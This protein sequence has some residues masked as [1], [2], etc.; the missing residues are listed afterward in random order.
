[1]FRLSVWGGLISHSCAFVY[2]TS[3]FYDSAFDDSDI[4]NLIN[5]ETV[6][7]AVP[8]GESTEHDPEIP[9]WFST[10]HG[11]FIIDIG[12]HSGI[13]DESLV[14]FSLNSEHTTVMQLLKPDRVLEG[15]VS[16]LPGGAEG[17]RWVIDATW[18][19]GESAVVLD[20]PIEIDFRTDDIWIPVASLDSV[21][22]AEQ[23]KRVGNRIFFFCQEMDASPRV[24]MVIG[25][26][27]VAVLI[28]EVRV[29]DTDESTVNLRASGWCP[30]NI[31]ISDLNDY[32]TIG[33]TILETNDVV[34]DGPN[35][36]ILVSEKTG[37]EPA[38]PLVRYHLDNWSDTQTSVEW[39][40]S[41]GELKDTDFIFTKLDIDDGEIELICLGDV[42]EDVVPGELQDNWVGTPRIQVFGDSV[43]I[44]DTLGWEKHEV[45]V[46]QSG[47]EIELKFDACGYRMT[48]N[49]AN[50]IRGE[51]LVFVPVKGPRTSGEFGVPFWPP[52]RGSSMMIS[53]SRADEIKQSVIGDNRRWHGKPVLETTAADHV[54]IRADASENG[55]D[56]LVELISTENLDMRLDFSMII[57]RYRPDSGF[58]FVPLGRTERSDSEFEVMLKEGEV[59]RF[60]IAADGSINLP[61][62]PPVG[63][64]FRAHR[65]APGPA[66]WTG[67]PVLSIDPDSGIMRISPSLDGEVWT[68]SCGWQRVNTQYPRLVFSALP[69]RLQIDPS[70]LIDL[71]SSEWTLRSAADDWTGLTATIR[72]DAYLTRYPDGS[73]DLMLEYVEGPI[74]STGGPLRYVGRPTISV[75]HEGDLVVRSDGDTRL[76]FYV[77]VFQDPAGPLHVIFRPSEFMAVGSRPAVVSETGDACAIC[78]EEYGVG[79]I[80]A[81]TVCNHRFHLECLERTRGMACPLCRGSLVLF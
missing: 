23:E 29:H 8:L 26:A 4:M 78:L 13:Y 73:I 28:R 1:M 55:D 15:S 80:I 57:R 36:R 46:L 31:Q 9:V 6:G 32:P 60:L 77:E 11:N 81:E 69:K 63:G 47:A 18:R 75:N 19:I 71:T 64:N 74:F 41:S 70:A 62:R 7:W 79:E 48:R 53:N 44:T 34:L 72:K 10:E 17:G 43:V 54:I 59:K 56:R 16:T 68:Y 42:C 67:E 51:R 2:Q 49:S 40:R 14:R 61:V 21:H 66:Q 5:S 20:G 37:V 33:R 50:S 35:Q 22:P 24:N 65:V 45:D 52:F 25:T 76:D 30:M 27:R 58:E 3:K 12:E 39:R 38:T